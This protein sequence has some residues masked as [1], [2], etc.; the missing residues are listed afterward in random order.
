MLKKKNLVLVP[1]LKLQKRYRVFFFSHKS[2]A[3]VIC[4]HGLLAPGNSGDFDFCPSLRGH[5]VGKNYGPFPP[6][7]VMFSLLY[8][9]CPYKPLVFPWYCGDSGKV[10]VQL[11]PPAPSG[12]GGPWLQMSSA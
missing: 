3:L 11:Y 2:N 9:A 10:K 12:A 1:V 4:N 6:Q 5:S 8:H 7:S